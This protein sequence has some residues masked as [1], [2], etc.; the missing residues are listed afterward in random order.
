MSRQAGA[1]ERVSFVAWRGVV[2]SSGTRW[3][4]PLLI[5]GAGIP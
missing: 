2:D 1:S 5:M 3:T 4:G